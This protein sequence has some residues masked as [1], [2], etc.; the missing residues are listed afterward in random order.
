[1]TILIIHG[2]DGFAG[3]HWQQ[4][5]HDQLVAKGHIVLMPNFPNS[6]HPER[7][8]WLKTVEKQLVDVNLREL[9]IV[10][11]SLGVTTGLDFLEQI[12]EKI[13]AF[14]SISGFAED[15]GSDLNRYFLSKKHIDFQEVRKHLENSVVIYSDNDPYLSQDVL[16]LVAEGLNVSPKIIPNGGHL[17]TD[18]GYTTFSYL[19]K[20]IENLL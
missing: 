7:K 9:M 5:L 8:A 18:S 15:Y 20:T 1:M 14:I 13:K 3:I 2:I 4:W 16:Y 10:G 17:N 11:H 6:H 12:H 19:L